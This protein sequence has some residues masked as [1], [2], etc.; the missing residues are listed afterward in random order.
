MLDVFIAA[1]ADGRRR[2]GVVTGQN[3]LSL[4]AASAEHTTTLPAVILKKVQIA[5]VKLCVL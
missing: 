2:L 4:D 1:L 5:E 3:D